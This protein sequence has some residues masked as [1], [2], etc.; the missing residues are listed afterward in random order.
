MR[1]LWQIGYWDGFAWCPP[2]PGAEPDVDRNK[3]FGSE[4]E[5][6]AFTGA[7]P[8]LTLEQRVAILETKTHTHP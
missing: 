7:S 2:V 1:K 3:F 8:A 6:T 5:L 4:A